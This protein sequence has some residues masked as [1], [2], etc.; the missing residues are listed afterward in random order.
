MV[1]T[2]AIALSAVVC[3]YDRYALLAEAVDSLLRQEAA[4]G[5]I[6]VVIVD[7][8]PD[9]EAARQFGTRYAGLRDVTYLVAERPGLSNARNLGVAAARGPVVAFIDDDARAAPGWAQALLR[10]YAAWNGTAGVVGGPITPRWPSEP[11]PWLSPPLLGYLSIV[12][13]GAERR[14]L[15][16]GEWLA[17]C[18]ISFDKA[19]LLAVGGFASGL[20]RVGAGASLLS[21]EELEV[22]DRILA[23]GKRAVYAPDAR[24]EHAI[25][26]ERLTRSW[27]RRRAAWQAVSDLLREPERAAA[28]GAEAAA[29]LSRARA[30][31]LRRLFA[32]SRDAA[33]FEREL[34][35]LYH[36]VV[37]ALSGGTPAESGLRHRWRKLRAL[38]PQPAAGSA[39]APE[40]GDRQP[41]DRQPGDR[42]PGDREPGDRGG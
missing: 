33:G 8:S 31:E 6:E 34:S 29:L 10:T 2:T 32:D 41:G 15:A 20:G 9:R 23:T 37:S 35:L 28:R 17:G 16:A 39:S 26:V 22:T 14:E 21:N 42:R 13:R 7:N 11:P 19:A 4:P 38:L 3:T 40:W 18:N 27:F 5:S 24:V 36:L 1:E 12:D 25:G 30:G